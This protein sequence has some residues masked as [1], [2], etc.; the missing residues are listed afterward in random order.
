MDQY[1][2]LERDKWAGFE[3]RDRDLLTRLY[4]TDAI[5]IGYGSDGSVGARRTP[6]LIRGLDDVQIRDVVLDDFQTVPLGEDAAIVTYRATY[7][8]DG[9]AKTVR[10]SSVWHRADDGWKTKFFQATATGPQT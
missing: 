6:D 3:A 2:Q 1:I 4:D 5:S 7:R 9:T 8:S 10:A